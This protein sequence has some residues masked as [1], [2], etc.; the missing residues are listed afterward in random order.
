MRK[1]ATLKE[2]KK[3]YDLAE[4]YVEMKPWELLDNGE[5]VCVSFSEED[6]AY[7]TVMGNGGM[8]YGFGLYLGDIA[9][10]EMQIQQFAREGEEYNHYMQNCI[11]MFMDPKEDVPP[12][13]MEVIQKLGRNYGKGR[14]WIYFENHARGYFPYI[15][16]RQDVLNTTRF[17]EALM[18][19][20]PRIEKM[21]PRGVHLM[22]LGFIHKLEQS[23]WKTGVTKWN[24]AELRK[25]PFAVHGERLNS[26][27]AKWKKLK[28]T[29]EVDLI[30][31]HSLVKDEKYDRPLFP[32]MLVVMDHK[33]GFVIYQQLLEPS[34]DPPALCQYLTD[35]MKDQGIPKKIL[36]SGYTM[37]E[38]LSA[39]QSAI[40]VPVETDRLNHMKEFKEAFQRNY[41]NRNNDTN[42]SMLKAFGLT[43]E[44]IA[45]LLE[46]SGA[47]TEEELIKMLES[48]L[49]SSFGNGF[50]GA[51]FGNPGDDDILFG[52]DGFDEEAFGDFD[53]EEDFD[54]TWQKPKNMRERIRLINDFFEITYEYSKEEFEDDDESDKDLAPGVIDAEWCDDWKK[55]LEQC[56]TAKLKEMA[57]ILG[58][59]SGKN[60][61]QIASGI[62]DILLEK[63]ARVKELLSEDEKA[64]MKRLRTMVNKQDTEMSDSFPFARETVV[65]L[66]EK[67]MADIKYG[68]SFMEVFLTL[69]I[70]KQMKGL[71]L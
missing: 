21:K 6:R 17:L 60:K 24:Q 27:A 11:V 30:L 69:M 42:G 32:Y 1:E 15:P 52:E 16:D 51:F 49:E 45:S 4:K 47:E 53:E 12:E 3:L 19:A 70:P 59:S 10:R 61:A 40:G 64:L 37:K 41:L 57:K 55:I 68:Q 13:Q 66:V 33:K 22:G 48:N 2:W 50:G 20:L 7:F 23:E 8:E 67:G 43:E 62:S 14:K 25:L 18:E 36:V 31:L 26:E 46:K 38:V 35:F 5:M 28:T 29:W 39:L 65:S 71:R 54:L 56:S 58:I 34:D 44:E 63:P 9:F